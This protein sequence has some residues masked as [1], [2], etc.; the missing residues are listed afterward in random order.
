MSQLLAEVCAQGVKKNT[1][2]VGACIETTQKFDAYPATK[3]T[4]N[5]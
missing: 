3:N 4:V 5:C 2:T 1:R